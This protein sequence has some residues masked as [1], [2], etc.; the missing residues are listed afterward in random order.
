MKSTPVTP[1][2]VQKR[3][4]C[5]RLQIDRGWTQLILALGIQARH[6]AGP[7]LRQDRRRE[8]GHQVNA[9]SFHRLCHSQF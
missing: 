2:G 1:T 8:L 3:A 4:H 9:Y 5:A 7:G 6:Q